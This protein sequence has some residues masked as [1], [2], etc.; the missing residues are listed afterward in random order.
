VLHCGDG[1]TASASLH[2]SGSNSVV[3]LAGLIVPAAQVA[4]RL[5]LVAVPTIAFLSSHLFLALKSDL[6]FRWAYMRSVHKAAGKDCPLDPGNDAIRVFE[7][8]VGQAAWACAESSTLTKKAHKSP[9]AA[10]GRM[11]RF[12]GLAEAPIEIPVESVLTSASTNRHQFQ[13]SSIIATIGLIGV[14]LTAS[15]F[16]PS[17]RVRQAQLR[18]TNVLHFRLA[19]RRS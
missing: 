9:S 19:T 7:R 15:R 16:T 1:F 2:T 14:A 4:P 13:S 11:A 6:T 10:L 17:S 8:P 5:V 18:T 12:K 3:L